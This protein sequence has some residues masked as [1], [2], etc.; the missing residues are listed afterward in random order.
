MKKILKNVSPRIKF[1]AAMVGFVSSIITIINFGIEN[2]IKIIKNVLIGVLHF[3]LLILTFKVSIWV[4][5]VLI[6]ILFFV[7]WI[8]YKVKD[9]SN[10][11]EVDFLNYKTDMYKNWKITWNYD[12]A[13]KIINMRAICV[14]GCELFDN[15]YGEECPNC[16]QTYSYFNAKDIDA[17]KKV[18]YYRIKQGDYK[19]EQ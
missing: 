6:I 11:Y 3:I 19:I 16:G 10:S 5:V 4:I 12:N 15:Y 13:Y 17:A 2:F 14:C 8:V 18:I 1:I 7:L 9:L